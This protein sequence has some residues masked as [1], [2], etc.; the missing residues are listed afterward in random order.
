M[1]HTK[2]EIEAYRKA[3]V[4]ELVGM[5]EEKEAEVMGQRSDEAIDNYMEFNTPHDC[6]M[7]FVM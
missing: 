2:E 5:G 6:A 1:K 4:A 7:M 3:V